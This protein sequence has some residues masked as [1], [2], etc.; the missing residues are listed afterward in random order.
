[1]PTTDP[2]TGTSRP[3]AAAI[4]P[5]ALGLAAAAALGISLGPLRQLLDTAATTIVGGH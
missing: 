3:R 2:P 1:V 5:L 4:A